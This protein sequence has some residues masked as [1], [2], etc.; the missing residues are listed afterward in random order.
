MSTF[1][2][3]ARRYKV[4]RMSSSPGMT[5]QLVGQFRWLRSQVIGAEQLCDLAVQLLLGADDITLRD[6]PTGVHLTASGVVVDAA[7]GRVL[8]LWHPRYE[9]WL[10]LGGHCD[11]EM[12]LTAVALRE[13]REESGL[14]D[15]EIDPWPIGIDMHDGEPGRAPH[16]HIDVR[17][18]VAAP[19][20]SSEL[21]IHSPEGHTLLWVE[22][23]KI[24]DPTLRGLAQLAV[25]TVKANSRLTL[26]QLASAGPLPSE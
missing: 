4:A 3:N 7:L 26:L 24:E 12:D 5:E 25:D 18:A 6:N 20:N 19:R 10:Q 16:H 14:L 11:G 21:P 15:L 13:I 1:A 9:R 8:L 23:Y 22:P 17:F 2:A